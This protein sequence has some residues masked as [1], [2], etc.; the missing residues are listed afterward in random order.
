MPLSFSTKAAVLFRLKRELH[1][2]QIAPIVFFT[3]ADWLND[4]IAC[5]YKVTSTLGE[6][7]WIVRSSCQLEDNS[8]ESNA[9]AYLTVKNVTA[10]DLESSIDEVIA[11]YGNAD[12][13]DEILIQPMLQNVK[14][15]GV[16][17]SHDPSTG[18]PYRVVNW[19]E[20]EDTSAITSGSGGRTWIQA[21]K[22][23]V[24]PPKDLS[25]VFVLL[26]E[27]LSL[28][29]NEPLEFEFAVTSPSISEQPL[30]ELE[31]P[32][33]W[34]LQVRRL[35]L[36][37]IP[38]CD[39]IQFSRL[40]LIQKKVARAMQPHPFLLG[41][42][43]VY[44]VMPDWN[45]AEI[46]GLRPKPLALSLYRE[47]V[48]DSVWADQ[49]QNYGYR[50]LRG[51]PLMTHFFGMPYIDVRLSLNSFI[52]A[53]LKED[54]AKKLFNH[55]LNLLTTQPTLHDKI[56]SDIVFSCY[57]FDISEKIRA[58]SKQGFDEHEIETV[59]DSLRHLTNKIINPTNGLW[60]EDQEKL[61]IL[62]AQ[63]NELLDSSTDPLDKI[64]WL[65]L[66]TK[67][68]GTPAFAGLAR[69][70]FVAIEILK[71]LTSVGIF[72]QADYHAFIAGVTTVSGQLRR[73]L[74]I[75]SKEEFLV[76]YGHLRPGTYDI[77]SPRYDEQP[78]LYF[79]WGQCWQ[80]PALPEEFFLNTHQTRAIDKLLKENG[81][82]T[83][84]KAL[85]D[86]LRTAIELREYAKFQLT[87][88]LSDTLALISDYGKTLSI[89]TE[90]LS[91]CDISQIKELHLTAIDPS[92]CLQHSIQKGKSDFDE[93]L[94]VSL[95]P[96]ITAPD[97]VWAFELPSTVPNFITLKQITAPVADHTDRK[98]L[99]GALV[100]IPSADPGFDWLF[101]FPIAGLITAWGGAN[102]HM[103][104]R[105]GEL[106]LPAVLGVGEALYR[107]YSSAKSLHLDCAGRRVEVLL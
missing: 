105:A 66:D 96:L 81:L 18:S 39:E 6:G 61:K 4:R 89:S 100:C 92:N 73:D 69:S 46:I 94:S 54:T 33:L 11:S 10:I 48:T 82:H 58:L 74:A 97:D 53:D 75:M 85:L 36:H 84:P 12:T 64:Y 60:R 99:A 76:R 37:K 17:F 107:L 63:R 62:Q 23:P 104:I 52:P 78:D 95:P 50:N 56:E 83:S 40:K 21:A 71:S 41:A 16:M 15:S 47:L 88:N 32:I 102:S 28:F 22:S 55:Y 44:G 59:L 30:I 35:I 43:T 98:N 14:S 57:T 19:S 106:G 1:T 25:T 68:Y 20:G 38:E 31:E 91:F 90:D 70:A 29:G 9:G 42:K 8:S 67:R 101:T 7:P 65:L 2:A 34:L 3:V 72:S 45:P 103:A 86:F 13:S 24:P 27:L 79:E 87:R 51:S 93:T 77:L 80:A 49:R 26:N 5:L